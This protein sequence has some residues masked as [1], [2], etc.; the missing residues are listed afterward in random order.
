MVGRRPVKLT[1]T[2]L[3][4]LL[5]LL[6]V[7]PV[8]AAVE[9]TSV[10]GKVLL[11][12]GAAA[13]SGTIQAVLSAAGTAPDGAVQ[14]RVLGRY[15]GTIAADGTVTGLVLV[16]NDVITP[17]G[18]YYQVTITVR[19]PTASTSNEKWTVSTSPDPINIGA[20]TRLD[21]APALTS[22]LNNLADVTVTAP[23]T[24]DILQFDGGQWNNTQLISFAT[25]QVRLP[26]SSTPTASECDTAGEAGRIFY[27]NNAPTG[28]RLYVCEGLAWV[29]QGDGGGGG[30]NAFGTV[31]T[32]VADVGGDVLD[33]ND[34]SS[35]DFTTADDPETLTAAFNYTAT[36]AGNPALGSEECV[37]SKD[38][39]GGGILCEGSTANV[40]E[41]LLVWNPTSDVTLTLPNET[42]ILVTQ[43]GLEAGNVVPLLATQFAADPID[44]GANA[45]AT[46]IDESANLTCS[47]VTGFLKLDGS[48]TMTGP[49]TTVNSEPAITLPIPANATTPNPA[50]RFT[51][52]GIEPQ[53]WR[54][55]EAEGGTGSHDHVLAF[56]YNGR[57]DATNGL[58]RDSAASHIVQW[59]FESRF[60]LGDPNTERGRFEVNLDLDPNLT[61]GVNLIRPFGLHYDMDV[62]KTLFG[63][64]VPTD[65]NSGF[66][67]MGTS[68]SFWAHTDVITFG[69]RP[70]SGADPSDANTPNRIV[71]DPGF[72]ANLGTQKGVLIQNQGPDG[73]LRIESGI[74]AAGTNGKIYLGG[75]RRGDV[76]VGPGNSF[77]AAK[78]LVDGGM[79]II[80]ARV[81]GHS[82][83][84]NYIF[85]VENSA[86]ADLFTVASG[87]DVFVGSQLGGRFSVD[88]TAD[89]PQLWVQGHSTQ[90]SNV[91]LFENSAGTDLWTLDNIGIQTVLGATEFADDDTDP[92]CGAG[93]YNISA[94][95]SETRLKVCNNGV[96]GD[97]PSSLSGSGTLNFSDPAADTCSTDLTITVTGAAEG[98]VVSLG[99]PA[100]SV[101]AG[102]L[103][104]AWVTTGGGSVTVRHC[105]VTGADCADPASGTFK[106]RVDKP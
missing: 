51:T 66:F 46:A 44:C 47:A 67:L 64:G 95:L 68:F 62:R 28:Q 73:H 97:I 76:V 29:L 8:T 75:G 72:R 10:S 4:V 38:G 60:T 48:T 57:H 103:F 9:T 92:A 16:P 50:I 54:I 22:V 87:G 33:V 49:I 58:V 104:T 13:T 26:T 32:A 31:G 56:S 24:L 21:Q 61:A 65:P 18:T 105:C 19:T 2:S 3:A 85:H 36:L 59:A 15:S 98:D 14:Q 94:D 39:T 30:G 40:S 37:F 106:A 17:T 96:K 91:A 12:N 23:N 84:T 83:Q 74:N 69:D 52:Q 63:A 88:G 80:Q 43:Q 45:F 79:D 99:V 70:L 7:S 41:G 42:G 34:S 86:L 53:P 101:V 102:G 100:G 93:N 1:R 25:G 81:I 89:Q 5:L 71:L 90:T 55:F 11:P 78:L 82:T 20:I 27:D 6:W 77:Q 35:I